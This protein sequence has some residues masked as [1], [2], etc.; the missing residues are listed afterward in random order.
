MSLGRAKYFSSSLND[1]TLLTAL[2]STSIQRSQNRVG[3]VA[4]RK[5]IR[6]RDLAELLT[7]SP[8]ASRGM[9]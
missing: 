5:S 1:E 3:D 7:V 8:V 4:I 9:K 6:A 2:S